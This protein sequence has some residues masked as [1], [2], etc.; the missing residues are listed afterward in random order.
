MSAKHFYAFG[1]YRLDLLAQRLFRGDEPLPLTPKAFDTLVV[2]VKSRE[3]LVEKGELMKQ[4]WPDS[5]VEDANLTQQIF[6]LRRIL[7]EQASGHPYI[8]TL[9][10]RG[11]RFA[12]EAEEVREPEEEATAA[13]PTDRVGPRPPSIARAVLALS[14]LGV[15]ITGAWIA[16]MARTSRARSTADRSS[17]T[18]AGA[19]LP[20]T[21]R[22]VVLPF[23]NLTRQPADDWLAGAFSDSLTFGLQGLSDLVL[24]TRERMIELSSQQ[25]LREGAPLDAQKLGRLSGLLGVR[26]YV[27]GSYQRVGDEI[28]VVAQLVDTRSDQIEAQESVTD[29]FAN[30]FQVEDVLARKFADRF[31]E[32]NYPGTSRAE[33]TSMESYH[34]FTEARV[35]YSAGAYE[36]VL[37]TLARAVAVDPNYAR[38]WAL[39]SKTYSRLT[40]P[41]TYQGGSLE[42]YHRLGLQS[43][44]RAVDLDPSLYDAHAALA[45]ASREA[46]LVVPWRAEARTAIELNARLAEAYV[47]LADSFFA[48]PG[49]GCGRDRDSDPAERYYRMA[50]EL[51]PRFAFAYGNLVY[52]LVWAAR[53]TQALQVV[54]RGLHELPDNAMLLRARAYT[55]ERVNR[56]DDA[57]R[58]TRELIKN[59][60]PSVEDRRLLA[61]IQL[62]RGDRERGSHGLE[63]AGT[64]RRDTTSELSTAR[65]YIDAGDIGDAVPHLEQAFNMDRSCVGWFTRSPAFEPV[66]DQPQVRALLAKYPH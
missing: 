56:L 9:P 62:R 41:T 63:E 34:A 35:L 25:S 21:T 22:L 64:L 12:A 37:K 27:Y 20:T 18:S 1:P 65:A 36:D 17:S 59:H 40:A 45:L 61:T 28:K 13:R 33:T 50:E 57:D 19:S 3:R 39:M 48:A 6:T 2:L 4:L 10:R 66:M 31:K 5:F 47:L 26:Y 49:W 32:G 16:V 14:V 55:L 11:Y 38:A 29:R 15:L 60:A 52:H 23:Q 46:G 24:V 30:I 42:A 43:A 44:R 58:Q 53:A 51:D 54:E 7:G 8:E